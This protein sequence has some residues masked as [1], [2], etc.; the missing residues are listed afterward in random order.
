MLRLSHCAELEKKSGVRL[1]ICCLEIAICNDSRQG[2]TS[3][4]AEKLEGGLVPPTQVGSD[5]RN[6]GLIG[7]TKVVP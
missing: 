5:S 1:L 6:E 4:A 2:T 7:T 3:Q